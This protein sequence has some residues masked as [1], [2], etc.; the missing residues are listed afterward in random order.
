MTPTW[1]PEASAR[2]P[3]TVVLAC[4]DD[5]A[6]DAGWTPALRDHAIVL[7]T[8]GG[9]GWTGPDSALAALLRT[10]PI[11]RI[12][13][14]GHTP[15]RTAEHTAL[16]PVQNTAA[17]AAFYGF[18]HAART[19]ARQRAAGEISEQGLRARLDTLVRRAN[20]EACAELHLALQR[21]TVEVI[22]AVYD[23]ARGRL[24][25]FDGARFEAIG[26]D[27]LSTLLGGDARARHE[28]REESGWFALAE[29]GA[30]PRAECVVAKSG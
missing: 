6:C 27:Q 7:R 28:E 30:A 18:A 24:E 29:A 4:A 16:E 11:E 17:I 3:R 23:R 21:G 25:L 15:C 10:Q 22:T 2:A 14:L 9:D 19:L 12:M 8:P 20:L 5:D 26:G 1:L 13:V